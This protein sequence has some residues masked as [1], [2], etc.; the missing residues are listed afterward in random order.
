MQ[1]NFEEELSK[2]IIRLSTQD[3][4]HGLINDQYANNYF[5]GTFPRDK[6]ELQNILLL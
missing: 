4:L 6:L 5:L 1:L 2:T 3:T